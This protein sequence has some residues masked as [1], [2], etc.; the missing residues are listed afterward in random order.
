MTII[1][2]KVEFGNFNILS[3]LFHPLCKALPYRGGGVR[4][5]QGSQE[6]CCPGASALW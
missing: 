3:S 1:E 2:S 6:L 5:P 4:V